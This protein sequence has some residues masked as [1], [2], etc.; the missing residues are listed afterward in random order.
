MASSTNT[1]TIRVPA[2]LKTRIE[3]VSALQGVSINQ[4]ALYAF[5]KAIAELEKQSYF[6]GILNGVN[7][8]QLLRAID[9]ILA[10]VPERTV[11]E[12]DRLP[13]TRS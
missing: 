10:A 2:V 8:K 9:E 5:T 11:P 7:K 13:D 6:D 12:W 1:L 3:K 4:F